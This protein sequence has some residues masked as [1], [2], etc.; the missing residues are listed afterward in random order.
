MK[1]RYILILLLAISLQGQISHREMCR[2]LLK[3]FQKAV[4]DSS[5]IPV[6]QQILVFT[7]SSELEN[8]LKSI[9]TQQNLV[10]DGERLDSVQ[11]IPTSFSLA[12]NRSPDKTLRNTKYIRKLKLNVDYLYGNKKYSWQGS[13]SDK[14][15]NSD[16]R[17]LMDES[18]PV[19]V[20]GDYL[21]DQ[22][23]SIS[24]I[25]TTL[26]VLTLVAGLF[27]IRT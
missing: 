1:L 16:I 7:G 8:Y 6:K 22:P 24:I 19:P 4:A 25:I 14:L 27:F 11:V 23:A 10:P 15:T 12:L 26:G 9:V 17:Q 2:E 21:K 13:V 20:S 3:D 18:T 5:S